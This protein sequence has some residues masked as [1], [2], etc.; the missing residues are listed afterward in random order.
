MPPTTVK[1]E[2]LPT[3]EFKTVLPVA[4]VKEA[5][6]WELPYRSKMLVPVMISALAE[7]SEPPVPKRKVPPLTVV[8]PV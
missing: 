5:M 2:V 7:A 1:V 6:L 4:P 3:L 8:V